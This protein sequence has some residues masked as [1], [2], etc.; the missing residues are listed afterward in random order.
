[1]SFRRILCAVDFSDPSREA[2]RVAAGLARESAATLVLVHVWQ[3]PVWFT[4]PEYQLPETFMQETVDAATAELEV[5]KTHARKLRVSEVT[6]AFV[7]G[8]PWDRIVSAAKADPA[9]DLIVIGTHGR[10]G[11]KHVLI[12]SVAEKVVRHAPCPVLVVRQPHRGDA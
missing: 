9:C 4:S 1:M 3:V 7:R 5:W 2:M 12:G 8:V 11:L 10:T 6:T